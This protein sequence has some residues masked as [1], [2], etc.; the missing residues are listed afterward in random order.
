MVP[1]IVRVNNTGKTDTSLV[2]LGGSSGR[3]S[4]F[5]IYTF[6]A[7]AATALDCDQ[8]RHMRCVGKS[9]Q[10]GWFKLDRYLIGLSGAESN[11]AQQVL[12]VPGRASRHANTSR[13]DSDDAIPLRNR[14]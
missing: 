11:D 1:L 7:S 6:Y 14:E 8:H 5:N 9:V 2:V 13:G 4:V 10:A 12:F 3:G